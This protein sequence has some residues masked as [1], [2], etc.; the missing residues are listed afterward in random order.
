MI[1]DWSPTLVTFA[2]LIGVFLILCLPR[3]KQ[4]WHRLTGILATLPSL[5]LS[6]LMYAA[7]DTG[8]NGMQWLKSYVW[9]Q[10]PFPQANPWVFHYSMGA[11]GLSVPLVLLTSIVSTLA[12]V[13]SLYIKKRT[14]EYYLLL[15]LL[16]TGMLGVFLAH[17]FFLFFIF[18]EITLVTTFFLIGIWG[19]LGKEKAAN[20][21][22]LYNGLGSGFM[23]FALVG[24]LLLFGSLE[25]SA[26][27][28][29]MSEIIAQAD[30]LNDQFK[31]MLWL[32]FI[33][34]IIAFGIK[35]PMFPFHPWM[36]RVHTEAPTPVVMI[37]SGILLKMGAYGLIRFGVGFYPAYMKEAATVL[38]ILGLINILYGAIL[39]FVEK[40]LKKVLAYSSVSHMG[41]ILLGVAALNGTGLQGAIFQ[42]ISH[43]LISALLFFLVGSL[44]E[45]T[46][47]T[48][49]DELSGLAKSMPL[50]SGIMMV[51]A[52][53]LLGLPGLSGFISEFMAFLGL[54]KV[55]P[56]IAAIGTPG[57]ILAAVYTLRAVLKTSF[58]PIRERFVQLSD[59]HI[60][61]SVPMMIFVGLIVLI[62]VYPDVLGNP[63]QQTLQLI[64]SRIGG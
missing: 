15:L 24:F 43:G 60:K 17:D 39:A 50:F 56:V 19:Y 62:G 29:G 9:F 14:K 37:H 63:M 20:H 2:P 38:A 31:V 3:K 51:A 28:K 61:E 35:L 30:L 64:V 6:V 47:T 26:I 33:C 46:K 13:A 7:F 4:G 52:L 21:F 25:Y 10:V 18:F 5:A 40:E 42:A 45:R 48:Q 59:I 53:A 55:K 34:L 12:A 57:L 54:F 22:L 1:M 58:G 49:L 44:Y 41:I 16:Q 11:D 8:Q 27:E 32:I 23:L 36:L